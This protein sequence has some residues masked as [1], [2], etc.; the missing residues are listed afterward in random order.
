MIEDVGIIDARRIVSTLQSTYGIDLTN[1]SMTALRRRFVYVLEKNNLK[2]VDDLILKLTG[3]NEFLERFLFDLTISVTELFRDPSIW[4]EIRHIVAAK[5][6][7]NQKFRIWLPDCASG[8]ELYSLAVVL[9][10][11][12]LLNK[13]Q[14]IASNL[15]KQKI[16]FTKEGVYEMKREDVN[17]AN[18]KRLMGKGQFTDHCKI[19]NNKIYMDTTLLKDVEFVQTKSITDNPPANLKMV[20]CRN[21]L[22]YYNKVLQNEVIETFYNQLMPGGYVIIGIKEMLNSIEADKKFKTINDSERIFQKI[23]R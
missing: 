18:Y 16:E 8:E 12:N 15:S 21:V 7:P 1:Y 9:K 17:E 11:D 22:I 10:E 2:S 4:R 13:V 6:D 19:V 20:L 3:G 5:Q 14:I 23:Q